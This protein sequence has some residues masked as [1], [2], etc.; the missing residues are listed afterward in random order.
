MSK[1]HA[2][3]LAWLDEPDCADIV[4]LSPKPVAVTLPR[5]DVALAKT[6][7][8]LAA[9]L[10][11]NRVAVQEW[12]YAALC[13]DESTARAVVATD[14]AN[15]S[16]ELAAAFCRTTAQVMRNLTV[17]AN[18]DA[19]ISDDLVKDLYDS[20]RALRQ[21]LENSLTLFSQLRSMS[22]DQPAAR[23]GTRRGGSRR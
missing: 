13:A 11:S 18:N 15:G 20:N 21:Q 14:A 8:P 1:S 9:A 6:A 23:G 12:A 2:S 10:V 5:Q 3:L 4:V 17:L 22:L 19:L 7:A 16:L